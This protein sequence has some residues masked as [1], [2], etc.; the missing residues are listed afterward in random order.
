MLV[1]YRGHVVQPSAVRLISRRY[2]DLM[3]LQSAY[4]CRSG[5]SLHPTS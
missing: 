2:V 1:P 3:R 4:A 5:R